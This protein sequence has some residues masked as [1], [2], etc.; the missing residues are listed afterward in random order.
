MH[1]KRIVFDSVKVEIFGGDCLIR[2]LSDGEYA[3][4]GVESSLD[5]ANYVKKSDKEFNIK[6]IKKINN[7]VA[8]L[9]QARQS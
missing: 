3:F 1:C 6:K 9:Q 2:T 8:K 5:R 4:E 7:T